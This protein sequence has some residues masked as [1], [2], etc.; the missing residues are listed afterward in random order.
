VSS[1]S[2]RRE[3]LD[4]N[5]IE[6]NDRRAASGARLRIDAEPLVDALPTG[7]TP[8]TCSP[9]APSESGIG[10]EQEGHETVRSRHSRIA[11]SAFENL[12]RFD[13]V[14]SA[15]PGRVSLAT[16]SVPVLLAVPGF[17]RE[18]ADRIVG[19][20]AGT[21]VGDALA[22]GVVSPSAGDAISPLLEIA[23]LLRSRRLILTVRGSSGFP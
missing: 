18:T 13:T 11:G 16:A 17:T 23:R 4:V 6:R 5:G 19:F 7:A 15:E 10:G 21:P 12:A 22:L 8:T 3:R 1:R 9:P 20:R 2:R 14:L